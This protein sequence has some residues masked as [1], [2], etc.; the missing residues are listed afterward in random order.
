VIV[1]EPIDPALFEREDLHVALAGHDIGAVYRALKDA[2]VSQRRIA[3]LTGQSQSEV[4]EIVHGRAVHDY[5]VLVRIAGGL[6]I[7]RDRM[8]LSFGGYPGD[9]MV[10]DL[11]KEVVE[12]MRRRV[13]LGL[14]GITLVGRPVPG[15]GELGPLPAPAP[16]PLPSRILA[17]HVVKVRDLTQRLGEAGCAYGSDPQVSSA[18]AER[19]SDLLGVPG[20]E[21]VKRALKIAVA[22]LH[23]EAGWDA[24]DAGLY[25][26]A[27]HHYNHGLELATEAGDAYCQTLALN[28]AGLAHVEHGHPNDGLKLL[29][30][31]QT[32]ALDIAPDHERAV[33]GEGSRAALEACGRADS[34]T[35][36]VQLGYPDAADA[37]LSESRERWQPTPAVQAG[38]LDRVA[39]Q[40]ELERGRL[41]AAEGFAAGSVRLWEGRSGRRG[42]TLAG[43]VLATVYVRAGESEGLR[44]AH[45]AITSAMKLSSARVRWRLEP[46]A[47]ALET[48]PGNDYREL[49]RTA[50]R[51]ATTRA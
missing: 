34:A 12:E 38:D 8:G 32:K 27:M 37:A 36:L 44:L 17:L 10:G 45:E 33:V 9:A 30:V 25:D 14:A 28:F 13:L 26:R 19:A 4:S 47:A 35:A 3:A 48:R 7:P 22:E 42:R 40:L 20:A 39:A 18:A 2:G 11:P 51:V 15:L 29:Q 24:F 21:P 43:I 23:I 31:A 46:L 5:R 41:D 49:A 16:V 50:H 1:V 6:S